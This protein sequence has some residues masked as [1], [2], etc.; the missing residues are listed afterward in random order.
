[1]FIYAMLVNPEAQRKAQGEIDSVVGRNRLPDFSDRPNLP[2]VEAVYREVMRWHPVTPL[3][4]AHS[5]SADDVYN[6]YFIPKGN[7]TFCVHA[8]IPSI[9]TQ[10]LRS[11]PTYGQYC[12]IYRVID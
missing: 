6:G 8:V 2:Y 5:T 7:F 9:L 3:G 10:E 12:V 1:T 11:S 4:L